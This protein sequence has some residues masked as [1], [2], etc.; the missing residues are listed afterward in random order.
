MGKLVYTYGEHKIYWSK[1]N[2]NYFLESPNHER[3]WSNV[4]DVLIDEIRKRDEKKVRQI[5]LWEVTNVNL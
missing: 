5:S 4:M 2:N 1:V 3:L